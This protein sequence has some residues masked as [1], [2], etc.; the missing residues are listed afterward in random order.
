MTQLFKKLL[1]RLWTAWKAIQELGPF[2][3]ILYGRYQLGLHSGFYTW[4]TR[5]PDLSL[6]EGAPTPHNLFEMPDREQLLRTIGME[7]LE[8]TLAEADEILAG[9]FCQ[10]GGNLAEINLNPGGQLAHWTK[11][12]AGLATYNDIKFIWEPAR[13]GWAYILGRA[14]HLTADERY[15]QAFW[16]YFE[17]F[18]AANPA[19]QG[20]HW[21]SAQEVSLRLLALVFAAHIFT[22]SVHTTTGRLRDLCQ[23]VALHAARIPPTLVYARS[24]NNNHLLSEAA[25]LY[26]A[27]LFLAGHPQSAR[28]QSLGWM[29][30]NQGVQ[31]QISPDGTYIQ[32]STNYLRLAL[33]LACW[34]HMLAE[35]QGQALPPLTRQRLGAATHWLLAISDPESGR[36]PNLGPNDGALIQPLSPSSYSD[37]RP[38][39]QAAWRAFFRKGTQLEHA[40]FPPGAW[41]EMSFW[42]G[43]I[44][45]TSSLDPA[46]AQLPN[47]HTPSDFHA[48]PLEQ[49]ASLPGNT[50]H[51]LRHPR[52][53]S[54]AYLRVAHF[55]A[56]PGHADQLH[57][58]LWWKTYNIA[59]DAGTYLYN[60]PPPWDNALAQAS[61]HNTVTLAQFAE[62]AE[63]PR[64][65]QDWRDQM[66]RVGRFLY[67]E[68]AQAQ[69]LAGEQNADGT[70]RRLSASHDGY[71]RLGVTH[72]RTAAALEEGGWLVED[73]LLTDESS[74]VWRR[75]RNA[76]SQASQSPKNHP[77]LFSARLHW[78]LP[79]WAWRIEA[80]KLFLDSPGGWLEIAIQATC[81]GND[82]Q[83]E[84]TLARAGECLSGSQT[85]RAIDGWYSPTY[86]IKE[87]ALSLGITV[88]GHLPLAFTTRWKFPVQSEA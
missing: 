67:L 22:S 74:P 84:W 3:L 82:L 25:G 50:P 52:D 35:R 40:P 70:W 1:G 48:L 12:E 17:T 63:T 87:P 49:D 58:D 5:T 54:W 8:Q 79:D 14:Y 83:A 27:G 57:L 11:Y 38:A 31:S 32:H 76:A 88:Y 13:F 41:D 20:P 30:F 65:P 56:R 62:Q 9:R 46:R 47:R 71:H 18:V 10:F 45:S 86:G 15:P 4:R 33:Q 28:W 29:W 81:A 68:W 55:G 6:P 53:Q 51:I 64:T 36:T 39:L 80:G 73:Q 69:E 72:Q 34:F 75:T 43:L 24:Q 26:T 61:V 77:P 59:L 44:R 23:A 21:A 7:G 42:Y 16:S 85:V 37:Y 19:Y 66:L 2:P 78:L 60:A